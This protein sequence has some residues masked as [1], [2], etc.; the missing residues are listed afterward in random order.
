MEKDS[1]PIADRRRTEEAAPTTPTTDGIEAATAAETTETT[2]ATGT[3]E[4]IE[5]VGAAETDGTAE[6][7]GAIGAADATGFARRGYLKLAG[8][9]AASLVALGGVGTAAAASDYGTITVPAGERY[10]KRL[11]D[12]ES[13][14]NTLV[15]VSARGAEFRLIAYGAGWEVRNVGISGRVDSSEHTNVLNLS[16]TEGG[17]ALVENVYLGDGAVPGEYAPF[18]VPLRHAGT[19][20]VRHSH[21]RAWPNNGLYA[22]APGRDSRGG[23]EG[24][25]RVE[26]AY[27]RNNNIDGFRLGTDGSYV[28]DS[29]VH[30][31]D[32]PPGVFGG[33]HTAR[34]IWVR[35]GGNVRVENTDILL[36]HPDG[37][38][39]II[40]QGGSVTVVDSEVETRNGANERF[41]GDV[42]TRNVG[43]DPDVTPP[44]GV[45]MSAVEAASGESGGGG[46]D[47]GS[48]LPHHVEITGTGDLVPYDFAVSGDLEAG[49]EFDTD[50]TDGI[51]GSTA[52]GQVNLTGT[53]DYYFSGRITDFAAEGDVKVSVDGERVDPDSF[54]PRE[55]R[56]QAVGD[57]ATYEFEVSGD[58]QPGPTFDTDGTDGIDG[59]VG[60]GRVGGT[61]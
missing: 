32:R 48:D 12:G 21:V 44:A 51:D 38:V 25:V 7:I 56:V 43:S 37:H 49:P 10:I 42:R 6:A 60:T 16:V 9:T 54:L 20:T 61:G 45:P 52:S 26:K 5:T 35:E 46:G 47:G 4:T 2:G 57:R 58:L 30:V 55:L 28:K 34:G 53:D 27:A 18:F 11:G 39:G 15:D 23:K 3:T 50:G 17:S 1:S 36:D 19:L 29:V 8:T 24:V 40:E 41:R 22:S 31:D 13:F 14:T 33:K 59:S